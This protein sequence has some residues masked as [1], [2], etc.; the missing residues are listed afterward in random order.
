MSPDR[1]PS[2]NVVLPP[3]AGGHCKS[4]CEHH[5]CA[6]ERQIAGSVC[7]LCGELI[8]YSRVYTFFRIGLAHLDCHAVVILK[9]NIT[10]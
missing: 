3:G 10:H 1:Q 7:K 9:E 5:E 2:Q 6:F 4:D 8:G